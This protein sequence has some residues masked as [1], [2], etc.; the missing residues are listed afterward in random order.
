MNR[1]RQELGAAPYLALQKLHDLA[2]L[3]AGE[4]EVAQ[5]LHERKNAAA[6]KEDDVAPRLSELGG[7]EPTKPGAQSEGAEAE[8]H[9]PLGHARARSPLS[10]A[11]AFL[12]N[13]HT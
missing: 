3:G 11:H 2:L 9:M 12:S 13:R 1:T 5:T 7:G 6:R 10:E 4:R 8:R